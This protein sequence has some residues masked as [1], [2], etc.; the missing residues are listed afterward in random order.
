M[1]T[2]YNEAP[3][4]TGATVAGSP[5]RDAAATTCHLGKHRP[6]RINWPLDSTVFTA[7]C[8]PFL[9]HMLGGRTIPRN[10]QMSSILS[11]TIGLSHKSQHVKP[12]NRW[13][14]SVRSATSDSRRE[15]ILTTCQLPTLHVYN[16]YDRRWRLRQITRYRLAPRNHATFH[17]YTRRHSCHHSVLR[18]KTNVYCDLRFK[19]GTIDAWGKYRLQAKHPNPTTVECRWSEETTN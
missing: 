11:A 13:D 2:K 8:R 4:A 3:S 19:T 1:A 9:V 7:L 18:F 15:K 14:L 10:V 12:C 5:V 17:G 6:P 16:N